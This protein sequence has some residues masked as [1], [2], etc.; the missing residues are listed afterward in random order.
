MAALAIEKASAL[1]ANVRPR[2][3]INNDEFL[4][5][6][7]QAKFNFSIFSPFMLKILF[8]KQRFRQNSSK[9]LSSRQSKTGLQFCQEHSK[10]TLS[11]LKVLNFFTS[12]TTSV[13]CSNHY[14]EQYIIYFL[15]H[16]SFTSKII[17]GCHCDLSQHLL[18]CITVW[19]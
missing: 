15:D 11:E 2:C 9:T 8:K 5:E 19:R 14:D 3:F 10:L 12:D 4:K 18:Y 1:P 17:W 13:E 7:L 16:T 6:Y